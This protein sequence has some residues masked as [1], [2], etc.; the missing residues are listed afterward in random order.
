[1]LT[2]EVSLDDMPSHIMSLLVMVATFKQVFCNQYRFCHLLWDTA[3]RD[4]LQTQS[5]DNEDVFHN[6]LK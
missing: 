4:R 3:G 5:S 2:Q 1:M 6:H